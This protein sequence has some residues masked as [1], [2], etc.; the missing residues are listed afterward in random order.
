[1]DN[2]R[3]I[4]V[5]RFRFFWIHDVLEYYCLL[6]SFHFCHH[7][8]IILHYNINNFLVKVKASSFPDDDYLYYSYF[9]FY[10][11]YLKNLNKINQINL[12]CMA[13]TALQNFLKLLNS[14][15]FDS[16]LINDLIP[17]EIFFIH[18]DYL[19]YSY[20]RHPLLLVVKFM[21]E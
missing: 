19:Q 2:E 18:H 5:F 9:Q 12:D 4:N 11:K 10:S 8:L 3:Y 1:M 15:Y 17:K 16:L 14:K 21:M 20:Y 6:F 7:I 13:T